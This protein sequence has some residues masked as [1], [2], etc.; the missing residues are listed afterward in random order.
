MRAVTVYDNSTHEITH[1]SSFAAGGMNGH[2]K[3]IKFFISSSV[4]FIMAEYF[5]CYE[6]F[7]LPIVDE[8]KILSVAPTQSKSSIFMINA[9]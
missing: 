8:S 7:I 6:V 3:R 9:S 2:T 1:V 5:A 4:P